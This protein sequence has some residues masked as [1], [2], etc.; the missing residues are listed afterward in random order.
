MDKTMMEDWQIGFMIG[1]LVG[2]MCGAGL[3]S[4]VADRSIQENKMS[5][6]ETNA[7]VGRPI[8]P[9]EARRNQTRV[10]PA[11]IF[12]IVNRFL[13]SRAAVSPIRVFQDEV[14]QA[15]LTLMPGVSR[16]DVYE[17][18]WLDFEEA[19]HVAGWIVTYHRPGYNE[20]GVTY[21]EFIHDKGP[22]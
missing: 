13:T 10:I 9:A 22:L 18:H 16:N 17:N 12:D 6:V 4:L 7:V 5:E 3:L 1:V 15:I 20:S 19:Y 21:W 2:F 14:M 11:A 8:T